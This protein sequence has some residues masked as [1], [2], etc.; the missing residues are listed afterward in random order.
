MSLS[1]GDG[2]RPDGPALLI[3]RR[4]GAKWTT[5]GIASF[6]DFSDVCT[7][8]FFPCRDVK[9]CTRFGRLVFWGFGTV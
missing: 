3:T 1:P 6:I 9:W 5:L 4:G 8:L 2:G 7:L